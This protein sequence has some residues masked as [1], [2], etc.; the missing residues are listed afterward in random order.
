VGGVSFAHALEKKRNFVENVEKDDGLWDQNGGS[1]HL[2][3]IFIFPCFSSV[4]VMWCFYLNVAAEEEKQKTKVGNWIGS[5][6]VCVTGVGRD[7]WRRDRSL[8]NNNS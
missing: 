8:K 1:N 2:G 7:G 4:C 3:S 6:C 5:V